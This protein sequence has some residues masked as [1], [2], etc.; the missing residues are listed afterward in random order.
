MPGDARRRRAISA[1]E[2]VTQLLPGPPKQGSAP[3]TVSPR[4]SSCATPSA[5]QA[6]SSPSR[7]RHHCGARIALALGDLAAADQDGGALVADR[8]AGAAGAGH[9]QRP[10]QRGAR[11]LMKARGPSLKSSLAITT[12]CAACA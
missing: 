11:F 4:G 2:C 8:A 12:A 9:A 10:V 5:S 3:V 7:L 6:T 1:I